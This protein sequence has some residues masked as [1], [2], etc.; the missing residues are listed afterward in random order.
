MTEYDAVS[1]NKNPIK[2]QL[3][4][5]HMVLA[6]NESEKKSD[7]GGEAWENKRRL[8]HATGKPMTA[9]C[10][11]WLT[12]ATERQP[13]GTFFL[14]DEIRADA[15]RQVFEMVA[16][17]NGGLMT[18]AR[19]LN[20]TTPVIRGR[21]G[22]SGKWSQST[23]RYFINSTAPEG[24]Y[25]PHKGS[26]AAREPIGEPIADFFPRIVD[27]DLVMRARDALRKR[28][29]AGA[30]RKGK[31]VPNLLTGIACCGECNGSMGFVRGGRRSSPDYLMCYSANRGAG[32]TSKARFH[33]GRIETALLD[34][35]GSLAFPTQ[36]G[37]ADP[38]RDLVTKLA[39]A[40]AKVTKADRQ[41]TRLAEL[42]A[43]DEGSPP[44][45]VLGQIRRSERAKADFQE[46]CVQLER[47]IATVRA[48]IPTHERHEA[49]KVALASMRRSDLDDEGR[50]AARLRMQGLLREIVDF[51]VCEPSEREATVIMAGAVMTFVIEHSGAVSQVSL[52]ANGQSLH[53]NSHGRW[54]GPV[55]SAP[56]IQRWQRAVALRMGN[57]MGA[58]SERLLAKID[59]N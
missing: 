25:Q 5:M 43:E 1:A 54:I 14:V 32:C 52:H 30:G 27:A 2:L 13:N 49:A 15:V 51:V 17:D 7:R 28:R 38:A 45:A 56:G 34:E 47:D 35:I 11:A 31:G 23:I 16:A 26:G 29:N 40:K 41:A 12:P 44:A 22:A 20:A 24:I 39:E 3:S 21:K 36:E 57:R 46:Q 8:A 6:Y 50:Y 10:P 55:P 18:V 19:K 58:L 4:L 9:A 53:R 48:Q 37:S 59:T 42:L 33:Y